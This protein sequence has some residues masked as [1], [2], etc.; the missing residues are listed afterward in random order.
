MNNRKTQMI[1]CRQCQT[2]K[3]EDQFFRASKKKYIDRICK[4]CKNQNLK[5]RRF[6]QRLRIIE[7]KGGKCE[8]CDVVGSPAIYDLHHRDP[9][10]K[11]FQVNTKNLHKW[12]HIVDEIDKCH[13]LCANCH[14]EVH[15]LNDPEWLADTSGIEPETQT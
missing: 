13:L 9:A 5:K 12:E 3:E 11:E 8:R 15:F 2:D 1:T 7:Y 14:R 10:K 4:T 6:E